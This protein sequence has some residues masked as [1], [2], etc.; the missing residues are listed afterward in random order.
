MDIIDIMLARAMTPQGKTEAYVAKANRAAQQAAAAEA[1]AT[2]AIQT[3][4]NAADEIATAREEAASLLEEAQEALETAQSAQINTLDMEDVDDEIKQ[5]DHSINVA[6]SGTV[7]TINLVTTYPDDTTDT[8]TITK[9]YKTT[10]TNQDGSMTQKAITD[11]LNTK[12]SASDLAAKADKTYVDQQIAAIPSGGGSGGGNMNGHITSDD[13]GHLVVVDENGNLIASLATDEAVIE[14][15]L[16]AGTYTAQNAVGLDIDYSNRVFS[17]VQEAKNKT[18]GADFDTYPMYGGRIKCNVADD[19]TINAFY[20]DNNYTEDGSNGQVMIYQPK[21]YYK[22]I[23]RVS[24]ES[25]NGKVIR[26]ETLIITATEQPGFKLAPIF[27]DNLEYVLLPAYDGSLAEGKLA[28]IAGVRPAN[29]LTR[30]EAE[31]AATARGTGWHIMTLEA[32]SANQMLEM[33]EFGTMNGQSAIEQGITYIPS[34]SNGKG[35]F[36]TGSTAEL[37]NG[38]GHASITQMDVNGVLYPQDEDGKRAITY[39]GMENPWGNLWSMLGGVNII[40][41]STK[42]GGQIFICKDFN[43]SGNN[44]DTVGFTLPSTY[45]WINAMGYGKEEYDWVYIPIECSTTANSLAPVGDYLWTVANLNGTMILAAG[46]SFGYK[47]DCGAFYYAA[48]RNLETCARNNY[49]AKLL[50]VPTKNNIYT[51][52]IAKWNNHMGG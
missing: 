40:G 24:D 49:G 52:N 2:A 28:S 35:L 14:A 37:G 15:L 16:S 10:G 26:H 4:E 45:G 31:A 7:N 36:I 9:L 34:N 25:N 50:F 29:L 5:L 18:M 39:R 1:S 38:T 20:G 30:D 17:R 12:A 42:Q 33:V 51:A 46:G 23:I 8:D 32:E 3:V 27:K 47:E 48:D 13:A 19:G 11:A 22:R 6:E 43:Y 21:F 44:Y 41:D